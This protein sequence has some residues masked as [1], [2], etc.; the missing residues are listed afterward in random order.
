MRV[1]HDAAAVIRAFYEARARG[2]RA[3]VRELMAE[4]IAWHD[5]YPPP[6]GGDLHGRD[7]VLRDVFDAAGELTGGTT[8]LGIEEIIAT[9]DP[10]RPALRTGLLFQRVG[11]GS[12]VYCA[13]SLHRQ[14]RACRGGAIRL[15]L[16]LVTPS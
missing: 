1:N 13:L 6:H 15:F 16:N 3:C 9:A 12:Y 10:G 4:D 5:P 2:D 8:Q 11:K 7:A 14:I